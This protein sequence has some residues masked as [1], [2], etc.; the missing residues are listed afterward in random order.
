M[1]QKT[2]LKKGRVKLLMQTM[3]GGR[4][5]ILLAVAASALSVFFSFLTPQIMKVTVD[6]I[7]NSLPFSLPAFLADAIET[8]GGREFLRGHIYLC[9]IASVLCAV[10]SSAANF[11]CRLFMAKSSEGVLQRLRDRLFEHIGRLPYSWHIKNQTGDI[12]QRCTS[13][14]ETLRNF[15]SSQVLELFR[16]VMMIAVSL[17]LMLL[18]NVRLT[19]VSVSF[20]PLVLLY[21]T[22]FSKYI[23]KRFEKA[24]ESEG[25]LSSCV[26][27]NLSGV[28]VVRA[29]GR[30]KYEVE[31]FDKKNEH[32]AHSWIHFSSLLGFY[33]GTGDFVTALQVLAIVLAGIYFAVRGNLTLGEFT[34]FVSYN[35][36]LS[37]PLRSLGRI[38][39]DLSKTGVALGRLNE[40]LCAQPE[41]DEENALTPSLS[42]DIVF[43]NVSFRYETGPEILKHISFTAKAGSTVG[44]LGGTG[45]GKSTLM[46]LLNRLYELDEGCGRITVGGTDIRE[47]RLSHLR[48]NIGF[49]LQEPFLFSKTIVENIK[50]A[51][52]ERSMDEIRRAAQTAAVDETI[53][54]FAQGYDTMVGE[55]G[56]TLSGGQKQRIAIARMLLQ[57]TPI[58][59]FDDSLSA[60]DT[61]TDMKIRAA[62]RRDASDATVFLI[63]HR[64]TTLMHADC[65]LVLDEGQIVQSGTHEELIEQ[66]GIY[67]RIYRLQQQLEEESAQLKA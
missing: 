67:R 15:L 41:R 26:Q 42:Q 45:S 20:I 30:E 16:V 2:D 6:S 35:A 24:D 64:I 23:F 59:I 54:A 52:P 49:V 8:L 17:S 61:Q 46:C 47:I 18:M 19:M 4:L 39:G 60:V 25:A 29:F 27:E 31:Q 65:I 13:D 38:L 55:K 63:S 58:K 44:I 1:E 62:L 37:W 22:I 66:E 36:M 7:L 57:N 50:S 43:D 48:G 11:L 33:W 9:A 51:C 5:L 14:V 56:V 28:R 10:L 3:R 53:L 40:I 34:T 21:S 12:I 32:F